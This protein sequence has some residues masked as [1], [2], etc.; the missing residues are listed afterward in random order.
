MD[1]LNEN[2]YFLDDSDH[3]LMARAYIEKKYICGYVPIDFE[4]PLNNG[5]TRNNNN[6]NNCKEYLINKEEKNNKMLL[7]KNTQ[8]MRK[9]VNIWKNKNIEIYDI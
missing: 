7:T 2:E 8:G 9:F 3:D 5:S 1:Y 6:Y 4:S